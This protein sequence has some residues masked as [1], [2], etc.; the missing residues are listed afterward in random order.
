MTD[1]EE[2]RLVKKIRAPKILSDPEHLGQFSLIKS[3]AMQV[4]IT[5]YYLKPNK[6]ASFTGLVFARLG[7]LVFAQLNSDYWK[8]RVLAESLVGSAQKALILSDFDLKLSLRLRTP[9]FTS[10]SL[11]CSFFCGIHCISSILV[12][13][14]PRKCRVLTKNF[15]LSRTPLP[16][17]SALF[18][19]LYA[20]KRR[21]DATWTLLFPSQHQVT[22]SGCLASAFFKTVVSPQIGLTSLLFSSGR[23]LLYQGSYNAQIPRRKVG[24]SASFSLRRLLA[25]QS[26]LFCDATRRQLAHA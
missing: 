25:L 15:L 21:T 24:L 8:S 20:R 10:R 17:K 6:N 5:Q 16:R 14:V 22:F 3:S 9:I 23:P 18:L 26:T 1:Y 12:L 4:Q 7:G 13:C 11:I 2:A 19:A